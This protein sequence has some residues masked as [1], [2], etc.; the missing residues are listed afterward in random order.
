MHADNLFARPHDCPVGRRAERSHCKETRQRLRL[1]RATRK[2]ETP[3]ARIGR[4]RPAGCAEGGGR[5]GGGASELDERDEQRVVNGCRQ[6]PD[7]QVTAKRRR[8]NSAHAGWTGLP[9][10]SIARTAGVASGGDSDLNVRMSAGLCR[11]IFGVFMMACLGPASADDAAPTTYAG[12]PVIDVLQELRGPG[13]EFIYSSELLP[14]S[15]LVTSEPVSRNR[16]LVAREILAAHGLSLS[17]V[18]PD[19]YAVVPAKR[20]VATRTIR[21]RVF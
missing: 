21:G 8:D 13:L 3:I 17:V 1:H 5:G 20:R 9:G 2:G 7:Q 14:R 10:R 18:R 19:L 6:Q 11:L 12:R 4:K 16:V 15:L